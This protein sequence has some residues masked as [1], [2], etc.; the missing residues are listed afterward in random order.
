M[1]HGCTKNHGLTLEYGLNPLQLCIIVSPLIIKLDVQNGLHVSGEKMDVDSE[2]KEEALRNKAIMEGLINK[3]VESNNEGWKSWDNFEITNGD[4]N[5]WEYEN[6][7]TDAEDKEVVEFE[8][9][10]T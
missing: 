3:D 10:T 9:D 2:L 8:Q 7:H 4:R 5:E 6:E 1:C